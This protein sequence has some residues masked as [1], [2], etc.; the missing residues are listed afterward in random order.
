MYWIIKTTL[1]WLVRLIWIKKIDGL[2]NLPRDGAF[3]VAANHSSY[4]DFI[5]LVSV[6][7]RRIYFLAA[8]KFYKSKFWYPLMVS[9]GQIRVDRDS[10]DKKEVY[11]KALLVLENGKILGIFP[12]GTRSADGKIGKTFSGVAKFA[13]KARV[14]VVPVGIS[15]AYEVMSRHDKFPKLKKSIRINI[16]EP[17]YFDKY[18]REEGNENVLREITD[19][20]MEEIK[21]LVN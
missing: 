1:G 21:K 11:K 10:P 14:P 12:E 5:S 2:K 7:P 16:G 20:I 3:I 13:L 15:G 8:E 4:F 17:L 9:T 18:Y 19:T 6:L